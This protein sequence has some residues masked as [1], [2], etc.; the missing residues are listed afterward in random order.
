MQICSRAVVVA[1]GINALDYRELLSIAV[2]D[3]KAEGFWR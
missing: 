1:I 2:V 3:S